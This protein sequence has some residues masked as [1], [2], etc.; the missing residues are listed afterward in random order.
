MRPHRNLKIASSIQKEIAKIIEKDFE[1]DALV[2]ILDVSVDEDLL[3]T[4][5]KL[6]II[7]YNQG[8]FVWKELVERR[9]ELRHKLLKKIKIRAVPPLEF[10]IEE[11]E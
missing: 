1:F 11:T 6:G 8:P 2:T 9:N 4:K 7:P 5:I 3:K 10:M